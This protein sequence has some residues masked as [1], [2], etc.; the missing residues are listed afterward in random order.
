MQFSDMIITIHTRHTC[1][2]LLCHIL[3]FSPKVY[4]YACHDSTLAPLLE[5]LGLFDGEWPPYCAAVEFDL[6][7]DPKHEKFVRVSYLEKVELEVQQQM[8][9][10]AVLKVLHY[11][12]VLY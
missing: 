7:E 2:K 9:S 5:S 10:L 1:Y 12:H 4:L 3:C 11:I 8:F 6:F